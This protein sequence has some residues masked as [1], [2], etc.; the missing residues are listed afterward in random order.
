MISL[1]NPEKIA[2]LTDSCAD[3]TPA[4]RAGKAIYVVPLRIRCRDREYSDGVDIFASDIYRRQGLGELPQTSLPDFFDV[5]RTLSQIAADGYKKVIAVHLSSGLS[6]T[7]NMIRLQGESRED[8]EVKVF[9]SVSGALGIG[10]TILQLWEDIQGGMGWRELV[11]RRVPGLIAGTFPFFSVDTL[12]YLAKGGR[13]GKVTAMAGTMLNIKPLITFAGDGQLQSV[14]K[15]RG[16]R[17]VQDKLIELVGKALGEHKRFNLAVANGGAAE[18]MAQLRARMETAFPGFDHFW[19]G[20][21]DATLS[22][23]IGSGVLGAGV[24]VL[25]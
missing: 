8:L 1:S 12:E 22:V 15:V 25:D 13:I 19:E 7:Y 2:L 17:A 6:G 9:D 23:Y 20:E 11:E 5:G 24:Q 16:R 3:L 18:E 4:A 14:A 21:L 10:I